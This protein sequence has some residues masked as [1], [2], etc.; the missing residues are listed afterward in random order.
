MTKPISPRQARKPRLGSPEHRDHLKKIV[1]RRLNRELK[2]GSWRIK[3]PNH[4]KPDLA[5]EIANDFR[6]QGWAVVTEDHRHTMIGD[7]AWRFVFDVAFKL[8]Q[9]VEVDMLDREAWPDVFLGK[10]VGRE[11]TGGVNQARYL[12]EYEKDGVTETMWLT[13]NYL[14]RTT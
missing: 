3:I 7:I 14:H 12:V 11:P 1:M 13:A 6:A 4:I 2:K 5:D 10:I 8:H 9:K